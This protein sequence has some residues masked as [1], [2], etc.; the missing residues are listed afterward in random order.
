MNK[1]TYLT[2]FTRFLNWLHKFRDHQES[3]LGR[4]NMKLTSEFL[5][6]SMHLWETYKKTFLSNN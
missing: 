3:V 6:E 2:L 4:G 1:I 5:K